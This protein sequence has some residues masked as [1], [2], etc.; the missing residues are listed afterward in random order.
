VKEYEQCDA[1]LCKFYASRL[2]G[3][4]NE[5]LSYRLLH[6][7]L[8]NRYAV[9]QS[10]RYQISRS[11]RSNVWIQDLLA[12]EKAWAR[13]NIEMFFRI[14]RSVQDGL[15]HVVDIYSASMRREY[16]NSFFRVM[17]GPISIDRLT[18]AFGFESSVAMRDFFLEGWG[19]ETVDALLSGKSYVDSNTLYESLKAAWK[20]GESKSASLIQSRPSTP[21]SHVSALSSGGWKKTV[22]RG[23]YPNPSPS[24]SASSTSARPIGPTMSLFVSKKKKTGKKKGII[25]EKKKRGKKKKTHKK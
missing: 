24:P 22:G 25:E 20:E 11:M 5:F 2:A 10:H 4:E 23:S 21:M 18:R 17:R 19:L 12:L 8:S 7:L 9:Y 6:N 3:N 1:V 13:S 15:R 16:A 14:C